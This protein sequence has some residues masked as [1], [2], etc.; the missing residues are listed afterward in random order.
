MPSVA[1][2]QDFVTCKA[3]DPFGSGASND[4]AH[5]DIEFPG[6]FWKMLEDLPRAPDESKGEVAVLRLFEKGFKKAV[7]DRN[8]DVLTAAELL[9]HAAAVAKADLEELQNW[10]KF[11]CFALEK[12]AKSRNVIDSLFVRKWKVTKDEK[13][14]ETRVIRSRLCVR[15]FKDRQADHIDTYSAV[16]YTHL[17]LPTK[18]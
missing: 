2:N 14:V 12:R 17:T 15:G 5:V 1:Q 8:T 3:T 6:P 10:Q 16:S 4:D 9:E 11:C 18:A 7:I 13:G